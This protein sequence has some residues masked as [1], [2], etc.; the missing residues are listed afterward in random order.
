[1]GV[2]RSP[3]HPRGREGTQKAVTLTDFCFCLA[4][5][6]DCQERGGEEREGEGT[7]AGQRA[8]KSRA[9]REGVGRRER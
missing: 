1:M 4:G 3:A 2:R 5:S 7:Q 8:Q 6:R 9:K